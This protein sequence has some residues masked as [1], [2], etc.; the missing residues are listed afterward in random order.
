MNI[1]KKLLTLLTA[2]AIVFTACTLTY[3][4]AVNQLD[5]D[6]R[7]LANKVQ[8]MD[9]VAR[10]AEDDAIR[11]ALEFAP[12]GKSI[13]QLRGDAQVEAQRVFDRLATKYDMPRYE[14]EGIHFLPSIKD[15]AA[16]TATDCRAA[17]DGRYIIRLNEILFLRN[18]E[19]F[20]HI[21]VPH[22]VAHIMTCL[23]GGYE[24][25]KGETI[26]AAAHGEEWKQ[27]MLDI[28]FLE[29]QNYITHMLDMRSVY[30]YNLDVALRLDEA[31]K[32]GD[33]DVQ[34]ERIRL[35]YIYHR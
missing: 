21:I 32:R 34:E 26:N 30:E 24:I 8:L 33:E 7:S 12:E 1:L 22:E 9:Q 3:A 29:P 19:Y 15:D 28:G 4:V 14:L 18:Y 5:N 11:K 23:R 27:V 13:Y 10:E 20:M 17:V 2:T 35:F 6:I 25:D 31:F 16:G